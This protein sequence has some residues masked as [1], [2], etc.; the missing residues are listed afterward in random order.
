VAYGGKSASAEPGTAPNG[1]P[2][3]YGRGQYNPDTGLSEYYEYPQ[4]NRNGRTWREIL[5][6]WN[7]IEADFQD[8]GIDLASG[9]LRERSWR[10]FAVRVMGLINK[11]PG[12]MPDGAQMPLTRIGLALNPPKPATK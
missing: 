2:D 4:G 9:I 8:L 12:F 6:H 7:A 10:W 5:T 11:P 1:D 3:I